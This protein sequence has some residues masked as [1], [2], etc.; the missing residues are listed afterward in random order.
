MFAGRSLTAALVVPALIAGLAAVA[1]SGASPAAE[2][3]ESPSETTGSGLLR[4]RRRLGER[5]PRYPDGR[6][7]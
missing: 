2:P 4:C 1:C 5:E 6:I 7:P 3:S